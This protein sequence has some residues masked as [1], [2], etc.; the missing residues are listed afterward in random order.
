MA[1]IRHRRRRANAIHR[2]RET[3]RVGGCFAGYVASSHNA[4]EHQ[5][6][7]DTI[8]MRA[9]SELPFAHNAIR[10]VEAGSC[11]SAGDCTIYAVGCER[12]A[13]Y[14]ENEGGAIVRQG[15]VINEVPEFLR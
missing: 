15:E 3:V 7:L 14:Y 10:I 8:Q 13:V 2:R 1:P 6:K 4:S 12:T 11:A 5:A 9:S